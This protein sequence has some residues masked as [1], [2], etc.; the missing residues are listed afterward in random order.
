[1]KY[2]ILIL[3]GLFS[4]PTFAYVGDTKC[5][6][7][8]QIEFIAT[9]VSSQ[10]VPASANRSCLWLQNKGVSVNMYV[11]TMA[12]TNTTSGMLI[13][14]GTLYQYSYIPSNAVFVH[15]SSNSTPGV[16]FSGVAVP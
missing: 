2:L 3:A 11:E 8:Y 5:I 1:M 15:T 7:D 9:T 10:I 4:I 6:V 16:I 13:S 14:A 12:S